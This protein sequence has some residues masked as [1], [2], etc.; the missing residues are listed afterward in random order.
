MPETIRDGKICSETSYSYPSFQP[1]PPGCG[2]SCRR[3]S[4]REIYY[5]N[6]YKG[7]YKTLPKTHRK[8]ADSPKR[9]KNADRTAVASV[10]A[11]ARDQVSEVIQFIR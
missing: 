11:N 10:P 8:E 6:L 2:S 1:D 7:Q 3:R 9:I 5:S 4:G